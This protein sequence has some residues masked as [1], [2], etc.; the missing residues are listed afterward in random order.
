M[1]CNTDP[2]AIRSTS[3][4]FSY[5][6]NITELQCSINN[7]KYQIKYNHQFA[8]WF[9]SSSTEFFYFSGNRILLHR[10]YR[11]VCSCAWSFPLLHWHGCLQMCISL[12]FFS[13]LN[14]QLLY[15]LFLFSFFLLILRWQKHHQLGFEL[16]FGLQW[17]CFG[18][19][20][21]KQW[22]SRL[23]LLALVILCEPRKVLT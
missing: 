15:I 12:I 16:C 4:L 9:F 6:N 19:G 2:S 18:E 7:R 11:N 5:S 20:W 21:I 1:P 22:P 14:S 13:L 8:L 17:V 23:L 10:L 3:R